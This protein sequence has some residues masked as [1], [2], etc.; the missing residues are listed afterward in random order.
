MPAGEVMWGAGWNSKP[1]L[2]L[3]SRSRDSIEQPAPRALQLSGSSTNISNTTAL[4]R[5][6][7]TLPGT[8]ASRSRR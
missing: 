5:E 4:N 7:K 2:P 3:A 8:K 6:P 1:D